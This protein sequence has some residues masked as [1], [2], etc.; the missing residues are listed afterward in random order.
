MSISPTYAKKQP[1]F[2]ILAVNTFVRDIDDQNPF[3]RAL[4]FRT[5]GCTRIEKIIDDLAGPLQKCQHDENVYIWN[6]A[7]FAAKLYDLKSE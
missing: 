3:I 7:V 5:M 4:I 6:T 1:G 2:V